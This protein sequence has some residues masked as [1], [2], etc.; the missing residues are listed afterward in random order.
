[1]ISPSIDA[2][3]PMQ[4]YFPERKWGI[5][6]P[7]LLGI[8]FLIISLTFIGI[9]LLSDQKIH[10]EVQRRIEDKQMRVEREYHMQRSS[11]AKYRM[12]RNGRMAS[13]MTNES[14]N[15]MG[16]ANLTSTFKENA[17][18]NQNINDVSVANS[19]VA[20]SIQNQSSSE[21]HQQKEQ[22]KQQ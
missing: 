22:V 11:L 7:I 2:N 20:N 14:G 4:Q 1:M 9:A 8:T 3:H 12:H 19:S 18:L 6:V 5:V 10:E 21:T 15:L 13:G 17:V 16:S